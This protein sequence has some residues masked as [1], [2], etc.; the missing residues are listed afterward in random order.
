MEPPKFIEKQLEG[1]FEYHLPISYERFLAQTIFDNSKFGLEDEIKAE[2]FSFIGKHNISSFIG[3]DEN[4]ILYSLA[5]KTLALNKKCLL[6]YFNHESVISEVQPNSSKA[7]VEWWNSIQFM[8]G[9]DL[10]QSFGLQTPEMFLKAVNYYNKD[11][12]NRYFYVC[13]VEYENINKYTSIYNSDVT[14]WFFI[15]CDE[16]NIQPIISILS[17]QDEKPNVDILLKLSSYIVNIQI[18]GDE[19]Y[20]DYV[21]IQSKSNISHLIQEIERKQ[22]KIINEYQDLLKECKPFDDEWKVDFYKERYLE[23]I[24]NYG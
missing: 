19:S 24:K 23:I 20:L 16:Q 3:W 13:E 21:L 4:S 12:S 11:L 15:L 18:G 5:L 14:N 6:V 8:E 2:L 9:D 1:R 7:K 10:C 22:L 17:Q